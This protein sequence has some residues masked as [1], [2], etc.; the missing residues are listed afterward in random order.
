M[1]TE[2][3]LAKSDATGS[4]EQEIRSEWECRFAEPEDIPAAALEYLLTTGGD[5]QEMRSE[6]QANLEQLAA[7]QADD[8]RRK[9]A[10]ENHGM[11]ADQLLLGLLRG[12]RK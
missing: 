2:K 1:T 3:V 4:D 9:L 5:A 12:L 10:K 8:P 6:D 11:D 7:D